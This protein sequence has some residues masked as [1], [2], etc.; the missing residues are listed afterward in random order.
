MK[1]WIFSNNVT[2]S[3]ESKRLIMEFKKRNIRVFYINPSN[4]DIFVNREDRKSILVNNE[5][6]ALP[7]FVI[8]RLGSSMN[9]SQKS[10]IRHLEKMGVLIINGSD[11]IEN[12][13]DKLFSMQILAQQ[14]IPIPKTLLA[15]DPVSIDY[16]KRRIGF[17]VVV[18]TLS[19][20]HG[21]GVYLAKDESNLQQ[22]LDMISEIN[23]RMNL[24]IQE[25]VAAQAGTD[26]RVFVVGGKVVGAMKRESKDGDFRAN[27][28]RGAVPTNFEV[29]YD[30]E[31]LAL[32]SSKL[33]HLDIAGVDL[34]IDEEGYKICEVNS[35][36]GFQGLE[37]A[38]NINIAETIVNYVLHRIAAPVEK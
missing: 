11:S 37:A 17:P 13:K 21:K 5:Y 7:D 33:L 2:E 31:Y 6:A 26:I 38:T 18:K 34:L 35:A 25:F 16:I 22:L 9:Y 29:D 19:G 27:V 10:V 4:I 36:P 32:E 30:A 28:S 23:P 14:N 12:A 15:K 20:T 1:G 3:Y 24:I 8:P